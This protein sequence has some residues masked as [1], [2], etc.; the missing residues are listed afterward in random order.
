MGPNTKKP[1]GGVRSGPPDP[2]KVKQGKRSRRKGKVWE[3]QI[4][5]DMKAIFGGDVRRGW[6]S[7]QGDDEAD[8]EGVPLMW[9]EAKHGK[10][11]AG[12][13][14]ALRQATEATD[15]RWP[16]VICKDER[17][18]HW[19]DKRWAVVFVAMWRNDWDALGRK[20]TK[21]GVDYPAVRGG[22]GATKR[23]NI[24]S[25]FIKLAQ[26]ASDA[27]VILDVEDIGADAF[28]VVEYRDFK[29]ILGDWFDT[30]ERHVGAKLQQGDDPND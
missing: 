14:A 4:A 9:I 29:R 7:R 23:A 6:Q 22:P 28:V 24:P 25:Q 15:G 8:T 5:R 26:E 19:R 27:V 13:R 18:T 21:A 12:I 16:V 30:L 3:R 10:G 1:K 11:Q 20:V 17:Q 2:K